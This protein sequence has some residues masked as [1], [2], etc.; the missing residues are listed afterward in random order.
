[1]TAEVAEFLEAMLHRHAKDPSMF[2]MNGMEALMKVAKEP[3]YDESKG[4]TKEF[5]T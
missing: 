3:L 2:F 4:C 1:M 5:T